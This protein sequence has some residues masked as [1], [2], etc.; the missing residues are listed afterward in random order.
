[1]E[2]LDRS[3]H[4]PFTDDP[5]RTERLVLDCLSTVVGAAHRTTAG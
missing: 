5:E 3:G 4:W 2:I 1:M